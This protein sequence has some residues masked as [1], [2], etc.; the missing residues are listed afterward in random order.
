MNLLEKV[1]YLS[2]ALSEIKENPDA[3]FN[4]PGAFI[5]NIESSLRGAEN[6]FQVERFLGNEKESLY[7]IGQSIRYRMIKIKKDHCEK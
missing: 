7:W 4:E 3:G 1:K 6:R 5:K 2:N